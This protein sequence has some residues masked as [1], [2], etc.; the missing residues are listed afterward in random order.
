M[1]RAEHCV[2]QVCLAHKGAARSAQLYFCMFMLL[3]IAGLL[4]FLVSLKALEPAPAIDCQDIEEAGAAQTA[5]ALG[6]TSAG[7]FPF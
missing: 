4:K 7:W 5:N 2:C 3:Y 1:L 6:Y